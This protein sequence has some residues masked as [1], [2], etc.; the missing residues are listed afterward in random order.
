MTTA[1]RQAALRDRGGI[2]V[3][4]GRHRFNFSYLCQLIRMGRPMIGKEGSRTRAMAEAVA[5][6]IG[7]PFDEVFPKEEATQ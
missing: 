1:E 5:A 4:A 3:F 7:R 6:E 2:E